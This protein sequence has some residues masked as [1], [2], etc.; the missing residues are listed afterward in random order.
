MQEV[1]D[2]VNQT[3]PGFEVPY[4]IDK[5]RVG[6]LN[7]KTHFNNDVQW[8]KALKYMLIDLKMLLAWVNKH[9]QKNEGALQ[10]QMERS[11]K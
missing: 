9:D 4:V 2:H 7:I 8:T 11:V 5:E 3:D 6:G 10:E 1:C